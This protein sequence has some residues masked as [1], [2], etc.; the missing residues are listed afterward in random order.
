[1]KEVN[2]LSIENGRGGGGVVVT[3]LV[4]AVDNCHKVMWLELGYTVGIDHPQLNEDYAI[5]NFP[6][7]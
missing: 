5:N 1:M 2:T 6:C 4:I 7:P 3:P